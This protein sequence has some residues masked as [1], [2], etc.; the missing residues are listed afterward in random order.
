VD[1]HGKVVLKQRLARTKVLAFVRRI[2]PLPH[3]P[4]S[5][6]ECPLR[7]SGVYEAGP[8]RPAHQPAVCQA[9]Y[10]GQSKRPQ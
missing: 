10:P 9:L 3:G 7:G 2:G 5:L 4:G 1:A 6:W 8:Y